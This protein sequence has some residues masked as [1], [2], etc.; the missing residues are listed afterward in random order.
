MPTPRVTARE[1]LLDTPDRRPQSRA[2][3]LG[4]ASASVAAGGLVA[5]QTGNTMAGM[6]T[7]LALQA[8]GR[9]ARDQKAGYEKD[10]TGGWKMAVV[11]LLS[12]LG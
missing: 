11:K 6:A 5:T 12:M 7:T 4:T 8:L 9:W 1:I 10:G 2:G 3:Q